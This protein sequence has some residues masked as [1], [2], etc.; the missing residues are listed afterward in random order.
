MP[1]DCMYVMVCSDIYKLIPAP[2]AS[3]CDTVEAG[4]VDITPVSLLHVYDFNLF[5]YLF[6]VIYIAHFP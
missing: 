5:I 3:I 4:P 6:T 1:S 2:A